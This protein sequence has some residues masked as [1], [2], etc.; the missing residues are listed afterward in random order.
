MPD[1][2]GLSMDDLAVIWLLLRGSTFNG[3][4]M[5]QRFN[6]LYKECQ[7]AMDE[8]RQSKKGGDKPRF[9]ITRLK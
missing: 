5:N 8:Y 6:R 2:R 3:T 4:P 7:E 1:R 9:T